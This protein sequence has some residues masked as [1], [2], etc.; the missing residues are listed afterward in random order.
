[1]KMKRRILRQAFFFDVNPILKK[2]AV[3]FAKQLNHLKN[4]NDRRKEVVDKLEKDAKNTKAGFKLATDEDNEDLDEYAED[5]FEKEFET[6][7]QKQQ[8]LRDKQSLVG[9]SQRS[10]S[11]QPI[12]QSSSMVN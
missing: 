7:V 12:T 3:D 6:M 10:I 9:T 2:T 8:Y 5:D 4:Q 1:M 11:Q